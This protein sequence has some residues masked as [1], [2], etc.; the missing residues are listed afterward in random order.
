M[1]ISISIWL[2]YLAFVLFTVFHCNAQTQPQQEPNYL[3]FVFNASEMPLEDSY[4]YIIVGGGTAGCP[5]AAT[6]S[7]MFRVLVL[8]RGGVGY[9]RPNLMTQEGFLTTLLDNPHTYDSPVQSFTSEDGVSNARGRVLGGSSAINAGFYSRA[10]EE[11]F[12]RSGP[13]D[14]KLVNESYEWVES[15]IVFKPEIKTWQS[16]VRDGLIESGVGPYNGFSLDHKLGTKIGGSTFDPAG[17]RHSAADLLTLARASKIRVAIYANV[18]R[19]LLAPETSKSKQSAVGVVYCDQIGIH[20]YALLR[21]HGEVILSA[22]AIGTPQ[23]LLLSGIGPGPYLSSRGIRVFH[24]LP[25]VGQFLYDNPRN[26]ISF[27]PSIPLEHSLIQVVGITDSGVYIE[28]ASNLIPFTSPHRSGLIRTPLSPIHLTVATL[29]SKT[30][31]PVSSG[32]LRLASTDV[33]VNPIVRFNYFNVTVDVDR[34][35]NGARKM[36]Q[37]MRSRAFD[38]FKF[39]NWFGGREFRIVGPAMP[40]NQ[41]S[42]V[43]M[44]AFCRRTLNTIWHYHGGCV[45]GRVVHPSLRVIGISSLRVVDG[46]VFGIS[47]GTNPQA[48]IMML[49]RYMGMKMM[50]ERARKYQKT[51]ESAN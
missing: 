33:R 19:I 37:I 13:W 7:T 4:D 25:Y 24:H 51:T 29:I 27:V 42:Y 16:A 39:R 32:F 2:Q 50:N 49:G 45:V 44:A 22:G 46:S 35:V 21:E 48:T 15:Q 28:A 9:G 40:A 8:E 23:L 5:L 10:D 20:H 26:S 6:L 12:R 3:R 47:P 41:M 31:G 38:D 30:S 17:K 1:A 14:L 34:C 43:E 11:F 36:G 18:E